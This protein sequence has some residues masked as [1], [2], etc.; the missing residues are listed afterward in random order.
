MAAMCHVIRSDTHL[1]V[2]NDQ[3]INVQAFVFG[4]R[5]GILQQLKQ[6]IGRFLWPTS[7]CCAP[8]FG[9]GATTNATVETTEWYA[10]FLF[11]DILQET[12]GATQWHVFDCLSGFMRI[13]RDGNESKWKTIEN[14]Q[15]I[16]L[17]D[18]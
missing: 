7:L 17:R 3:T 8:L 11:N 16:E 12:L 18:T 5:F 13:L 6:E 10:L 4:I 14:H 1:N 2:V 15:L 9:L